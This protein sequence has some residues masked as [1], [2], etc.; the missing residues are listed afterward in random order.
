MDA[1]AE[2]YSATSPYTYVLN[3]PETLSDPDGMQISVPGGGPVP[4]YDPV[5][6]ASQAAGSTVD[7]A[8]LQGAHVSSPKNWT[9]I[10][11]KSWLNLN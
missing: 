11:R 7:N 1:M 9:F 3:S 10:F 6:F 2:H 4:F 5:S 8:L